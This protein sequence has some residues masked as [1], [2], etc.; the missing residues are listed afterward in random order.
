MKER[1]A[2][3]AFNARNC[4]G[5]TVET[6]A[7]LLDVSARSLA[8]Y[9]AGRHVPDKIVERMVQA[10][11]AP[12]LG[13]FWLSRELS[14]GRLLLP[15]IETAGIAATAVQFRKSIRQ[16]FD[17]SDSL[18]DIC[19]DDLIEAHEHDILRGCISK[20]RN[21]AGACMNVLMM[22]SFLPNKKTA[23]TAI[24]TV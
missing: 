5:L 20:C 16:I 15:P 9:E 8:Y 14:T 23:P 6:A 2:E 18:D 13:Y 21:L 1:F 19:E 7:E 3:M 24:G 17:T 4:A 22:A 10:Y 11:S 12:T